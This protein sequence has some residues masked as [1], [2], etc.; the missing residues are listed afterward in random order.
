MITQPSHYSVNIDLNTKFIFSSSGSAS[1]IVKHN[2]AIQTLGLNL[3]YFT[4]ADELTPEGYAALLRSPI[5]RGA[6]VTGRGGLKSNIIPYLDV[7]EPLALKTLA[8]NT[9]V[10]NAGKLY[11]YNSD[12]I[13]LKTALVKGIE[14]SGL[15]IR[16]AVIYG[17]G[18]VS[19]VAY[20]VLLELGI[21]VTLRG[22]DPQRVMEKKKQ[23]GI[24]LQEDFEGPYD[25]V[26]DATPISS[27]PNFLAASGFSSLLVGAK[28]LFCHNMPEKDSKFNYLEKY[29]AE[30]H[31]FYIPGKWMYNAQLAKQYR[32]LFEAFTKKDGS[33][34]SEMDILQT[35]NVE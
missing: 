22:R 34:I 20:H 3:V 28:M 4:I 6:A 7:V 23:L 30:H 31:L 18:G 29:C 1:S 21:R 10:N 11:G 26:V 14:A 24:Q 19:G 32:L 12:A 5:A 2:D 15:D 16:T 33:E 13:G 35:W 27:D 8:V 25:L 9:V 17:N